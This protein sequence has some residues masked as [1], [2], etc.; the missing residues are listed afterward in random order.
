MPIS[1]CEIS[2]IPTGICHFAQNA[3]LKARFD[4]CRSVH[5]GI[6]RG[7]A[8]LG[9]LQAWPLENASLGHAKIAEL[10]AETLQTRGWLI[11]YS[12]DVA[13]QPSK[14]GV[15]PDLLEW[16]VKT[17]KRVVASSPPLP[18]HLSSLQP[19]RSS[20][21]ERSPTY[22]KTPQDGHAAVGARLESRVTW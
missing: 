15:S 4:S 20:L 14:Y 2:P 8:D 16:A 18:A 1:W 17:A 22:P 7:V 21:D 13:E 6:N 3:I 12:H 5:P 10:I 19:A 11:F 9:S